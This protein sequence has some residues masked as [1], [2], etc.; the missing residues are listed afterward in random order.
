MIANASPVVP[1]DPL[2]ASLAVYQFEWMRDWLWGVPLIVVT[3]VLHAF[4]LHRLHQL[5]VVPMA[6]RA[7]GRHTQVAVVLGLTLLALTVLLV[8]QA[9]LWTAL[10]LQ[11]G[12]LDRVGTAMLYSVGAMTGYGH[13]PIYLEPR[14]RMLGA[15]QAL[16]GMILFG[17]TTAYLFQFLQSLWWPDQALAEKQRYD[18]AGP[19]KSG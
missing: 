14:W 10:Y 5:V 8:A 3:V 12:A 2:V 16:N 11:V 19:R 4:A 13:A 15:I 18:R 9:I 17:V 7:R 6:V 1:T